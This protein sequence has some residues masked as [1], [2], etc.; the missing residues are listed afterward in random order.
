MPCKNNLHG[1]NIFLK[2]IL[3]TIPG[4]PGAIQK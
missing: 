1:M 3:V 2:P 4:N